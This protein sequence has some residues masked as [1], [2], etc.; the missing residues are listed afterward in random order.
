MA[1]FNNNNNNIKWTYISELTEA[2]LKEL[3]KLVSVSVKDLQEC[4]KRDFR[5]DFRNSFFDSNKIENS[6]K[7]KVAPIITKNPDFVANKYNFATT[8]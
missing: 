6:L 1:L 4:N 5:K 8:K 7:Q 2:Q 3:S